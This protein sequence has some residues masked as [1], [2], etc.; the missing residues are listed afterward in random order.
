MT[1]DDRDDVE[2]WNALADRVTATALRPDSDALQWLAE[3][4]RAWVV[5]LAVASVALT[6]MTMATSQDPIDSTA[7][8][9]TTL[10]TDAI[11]RMMVDSDQPPAIGRLLLAPSVQRQR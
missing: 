5:T 9:V 8:T 7:G 2:Y 11:G 10:P 4:P 6:L 3:S 1:S